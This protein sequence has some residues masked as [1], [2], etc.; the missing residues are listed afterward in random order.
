MN[1]TIQLVYEN[2]QIIKIY[3]A[4]IHLLILIIVI[5]LMFMNIV[6]ISTFL[7]I[8][9]IRFFVDIIV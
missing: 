2:I 9:V 1:L 5:P 6:S 3:L 7:W 8:I 4:S